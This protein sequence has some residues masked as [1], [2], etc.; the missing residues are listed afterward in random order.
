[1]SRRSEISL[2]VTDESIGFFQYVNV[3]SKS[4]S[5]YI[6]L[7][8]GIVEYGYIKD[9]SMFLSKVKT[10]F[11]KYQIRP[12][13]VELI[14]HDQNLLI[15]EIQIPKDILLKKSIDQ[16]LS[17]QQDKAVHFPFEKPTFSHY[18]KSENE[19][20]MTI[21]V[22]A[23]DELLLQ[24]YHDI[25][26]KV[27][28]KEVTFDLS[29]LSL[30]QLYVAKTNTKPKNAMIVSIYARMLTI[31][32]VGDNL[33]LFSMNEEIDAPMEEYGEL[34][35]SYV[36]RI[37]NYYK[38]NLNKGK[39]SITSVLIFNFSD[40]MDMT[41]LVGNIVPRLNHLNTSVFDLTE[42]EGLK[43]LPH[44][45]HVAYACSI[46][47]EN[48]D[49]KLKFK[50]DR[51][52]RINLYSSYI[53]V[54]AFAIFSFTALIYIPYALGRE[55]INV[56][57][58][59]NNILQNQ[60]DIL[61]RDVPNPEDLLQI[62][63]DYSTAYDDL[64][65]AESLSTKMMID[66]V[67]QLNGS[68]SLSNYQINNNEQKIVLVISA[69]TEIELNEYLIMIY[70]NYGIIIGSPDP[71]RWMVSAPIRRSMST[72]TMEVTLFYA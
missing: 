69:L 33:P 71:D 48:K 31:Q 49:F 63:K 23:A 29:S 20:S 68:L 56:Q 2:L 14:V 52:K 41:F 24:D 53:L 30:Y 9:P 54:L 13:R 46:N 3:L 42:E 50:L 39:E 35:E 38:Y 60:L 16:Y 55:D 25:F 6:D 17:E 45:C 12:N 21:L 58:N 64:S 61:I 10:L 7:E 70:E 11:K 59:L 34:L 66:L 4:R 37:A 65:D 32:I 51:V 19:Q 47:N 5:G 27:G 36:E 18:I 72:L 62:E 40:Q 67:S 57:R 44:E 26:D 22:L 8:K 15:R 1:M 28:V 43:N